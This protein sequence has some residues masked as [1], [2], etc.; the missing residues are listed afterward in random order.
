MN[1]YLQNKIQLYDLF[2]GYLNEY[3]SISQQNI[4]QN[5]IDD[6]DV[7]M[8]YL[9]LT[10]ISNFLW[11]DNMITINEAKEIFKHNIDVPTKIHELYLLE[12]NGL[13]SYMPTKN[14]DELHKYISSLCEYGINV[15]YKPIYDNEY[16]YFIIAEIK[17]FAI[18]NEL[19]NDIDEI[20]KIYNRVELSMKMKNL[21]IE[22]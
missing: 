22:K 20:T 4:M 21:K 16:Y 12:K 6:D 17:E 14:I 7:I 2:Y 8:K 5:N 3:F 13:P 15:Y 11:Q 19:H 18:W 1:E 10:H 9:S